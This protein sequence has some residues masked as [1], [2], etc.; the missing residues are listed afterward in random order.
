MGA[1]M[2]TPSLHPTQ[3]DASAETG[4]L[5]DNQQARARA[6]LLYGLAAAANSAERI[7]QVFDVALDGIGRALGASRSSILVFDREGV[8]RFRSWRGLSE[9]YRRAVEGHSPWKKDAR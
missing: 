2:T 9:E 4:R 7:E 1:T 6:E 5:H 8:M 3:P